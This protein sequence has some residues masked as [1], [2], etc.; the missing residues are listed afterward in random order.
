VRAINL[1]VLCADVRE[2]R[3]AAGMRLLL[4]TSDVVFLAGSQPEPVVDFTT[5]QPKRD[6]ADRP[7][8]QVRLTAFYKDEDGKDQSEVL[9]VKLTSPS[10]CRRWPRCGSRSWWRSRGRTTAAVGW[11]TGRRRWSHRRPRARRASSTGL[12]G[13]GGMRRSGLVVSG[14]VAVEGF[15]IRGRS[16]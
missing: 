4:D 9:T 2:P 15:V 8:F 12:T 5:K 10:R 3:R 13:R 6:R 7:L 11:R 16:V 14:E 1:N